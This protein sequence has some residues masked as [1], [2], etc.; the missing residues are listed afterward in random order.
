MAQLVTFSL[1][2]ERRA[3]AVPEG[4]YNRFKPG[5]RLILWGF[6][7]KQTILHD[8]SL[9]RQHCD[10]NKMSESLLFYA[11]I[12]IKIISDQSTYKNTIKIHN[13]I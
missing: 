1:N 12:K 2:I 8:H 5:G 7:F 6:F 4:S 9:H 13:L 10:S 3:K 11:I